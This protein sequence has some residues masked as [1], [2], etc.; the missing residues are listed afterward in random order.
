LEIKDCIDKNSIIITP[1]MSYPARINADIQNSGISV[2]C[3]LESLK[4]NFKA[5][6][7]TY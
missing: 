3:N 2:K 6:T 4:S 1:D 7:A 5:I